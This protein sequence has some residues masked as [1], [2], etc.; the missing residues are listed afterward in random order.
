MRCG[1]AWKGAMLRGY[2]DI[3]TISRKRLEVLHKAIRARL[4]EATEAATAAKRLR[5]RT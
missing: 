3:A 1:L 4:R 2:L 5:T